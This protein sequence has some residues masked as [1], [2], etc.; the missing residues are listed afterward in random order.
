MKTVLTNALLL[1]LGILS[2]I[3]AEAQQQSP[4]I[5]IRVGVTPFQL[6]DNFHSPYTYNGTGI[7]V[8]AIY[9]RERTNTQL[10]V[11]G[12]YAQVKP[13]SI[14]SQ[15]ASAQLGDVLLSYRWR[16]SPVLKTSDPLRIDAGVG[17][18]FAGLN[19]NYTPDLETSNLQLTAT[20]AIGGSVSASY[21]IN[22]SHSVR[23]SGFASAIS[24]AYRPNYAYFG[25]E[26]LK[27]SWFGENPMLETQLSYGYR[28]HKS[29]QATLHYQFGYL[30]Y[31]Q[32]QSI[33]MLYHCVGL[34]FRRSF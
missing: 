24:A 28:F 18:R 33:I 11:T 30:K 12:S 8:Q 15:Q 6:N 14:V 27:L 19:I 20:A 1:L 22:P 9:L 31:N 3:P 2:C 34:G 7:G 23:L 26:L 17:L 4:Q 5:G 10:E 21:Q 32:P 13:A 29:W 16:L 25:K